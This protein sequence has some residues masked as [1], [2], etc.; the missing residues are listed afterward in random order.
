MY[1]YYRCRYLTPGSDK[2]RYS[3]FTA[4]FLRSLICIGSPDVG[5]LRQV[6]IRLDTPGLRGYSYNLRYV[7]TPDV[8]N[9]R[10][11]LIRLDTPGLRLYS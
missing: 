5:T 4:L 1:W 6:Q 8:D 3:R 9:L 10:Q 2:V 7:G 11:V